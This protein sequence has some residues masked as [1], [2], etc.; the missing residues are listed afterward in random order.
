M[1]FRWTKRVLRNAPVFPIEA[2]FVP[3][4]VADHRRSQR[5]RRDFQL[6][7]QYPGDHFDRFRKKFQSIFKDPRPLLCDCLSKVLHNPS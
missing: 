4:P 6:A 1:G 2:Q 3:G 5:H 7:S